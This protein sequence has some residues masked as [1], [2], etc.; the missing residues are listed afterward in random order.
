MSGRFLSCDVEWFKD[1]ARG[2]CRRVKV[3]KNAYCEP[4]ELM[5]SRGWHHGTTET[6]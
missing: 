6:A 1:E 4:G 3:T 2:K 5:E